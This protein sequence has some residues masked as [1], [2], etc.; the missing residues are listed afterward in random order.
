MSKADGLLLRKEGAKTISAKKLIYI[1]LAAVNAVCI[2][3]LI[4]LYIAF[5][6]IAE[7]LPSQNVV[8]GWQGEKGGRFSQLSVFISEGSGLDLNEVRRMRA[9]TEK[10]LTENS[11]AAEKEGARIYFDGFSCSEMKL[12]VTTMSESYAPNIEA[13]TIVTGGDFFRFH[14]LELLSG[15][16]YSDDD[17]MQDRIVI[18]ETLAWQLFGSSNVSGMAVSIGGK[19]F[20][21][22]GVVKS[23]QDKA[24]QYVLGSKP[25]MYISYGGI[26]LVGDAPEITCYETVLP[27]PVKG[28]ARTILTD[29]LSVPEKE[30]I[31]AENTNRYSI[32]KIFKV[33]FDGGKR[34]VVDKAVVYPYWENAARINEENAADILAVMTVLLCIPIITVLYFVVLLFIKR[35]AILHKLAEIIRE[36]A[37]QTIAFLKQKTLKG[38]N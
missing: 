19:I 21:V 10:K 28:L 6:G 16:Y 30:Y 13:N 36:K 23:E 27:D 25:Y 38:G 34:A 5:V 17:L 14:P 20:D 31:L 33:A 29:V 26:Q 11:L 9:D 22:A 32:P 3:V 12:S 2:A 35:K 8:S 24:S 7:K 18:D 37:G 4:C 1:I 15:C